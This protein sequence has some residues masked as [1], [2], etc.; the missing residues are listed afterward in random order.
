MTQ[1]R[2]ILIGYRGHVDVIEPVM[3]GWVSQIA[4]PDEPVEFTLRL[5]EGTDIPVVAGTARPDLAAA[6]LAGPNSGFSVALPPGCLDGGRHEIAFLLPD[7]R[8]L[9]LPGA[10]RQ[11]AL[12][13]VLP[14]LVPASDADTAL[15]LDLLQQTDW[16]AG[17]D[18]AQVRLD[19][20]TEFNAVTAPRRGF[21][22]YARARGRLVGY[23]R[24]DRG[25]DEAASLGIVALTVVEAYRRKGLG[26]ALMRALLRAVADEPGMREVWLSVRPDNTPAVRLYD[27]L[28]F[29]PQAVHPLGRWVGEGEIAMRWLTP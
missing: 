9:R 7:G 12:G 19:N 14:D 1:R 28:G 29:M 15:V 25:R 8:D 3:S 6:G 21:L 22:F 16:E 27:K 13:P 2:E 10:P 24:L 17:F 5:D 26:E 23:G 18:P 20:A 4:R 11:V